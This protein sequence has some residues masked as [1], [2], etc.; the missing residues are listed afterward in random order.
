METFIQD[1]VSQRFSV[2]NAY[3]KKLFS[4]VVLFLIIGSHVFFNSFFKMCF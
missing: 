1:L 4:S 2:S 3:V